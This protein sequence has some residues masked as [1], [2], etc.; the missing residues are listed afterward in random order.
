MAS[1]NKL[2]IINNIVKYILLTLSLMYLVGVI[3]WPLILN[4]TNHTGGSFKILIFI[5]IFLM[6][7]GL[8]FNLFYEVSKKEI[9]LIIA[10]NTLSVLLLLIYIKFNIMLEYA[11]WLEKGMPKS[12]LE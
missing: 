2:R 9:I 7:I 10:I 12:P 5:P 11:V 6:L 8:G 1:L 4:S 3:L